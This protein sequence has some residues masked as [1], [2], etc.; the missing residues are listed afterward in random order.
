[1]PQLQ[2]TADILCAALEGFEAQEAS[3]G[4]GV[5]LVGS[6]RCGPSRSEEDLPDAS[7][8]VR[9][10][11][12]ASVNWSTDE[13][14]MVCHR[15]T[16]EFASTDFLLAAHGVNHLDFMQASRILVSLPARRPTRG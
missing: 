10:P 16:D 6:L 12:C 9:G 11:G 14:T 2:L 5:L 8:R 13:K 1:M 4:T 7:G 15:A 3:K